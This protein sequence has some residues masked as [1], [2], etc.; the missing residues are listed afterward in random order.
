MVPAITAEGME[1]G[2]K[3]FLK[4]KNPSELPGF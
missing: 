3:F 4:I 2:F 1:E